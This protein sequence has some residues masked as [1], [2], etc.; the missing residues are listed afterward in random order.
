MSNRMHARRMSQRQLAR[1]A[2]VDHSTVSRVLRRS[3]P[4]ARDGAC[5][6]GCA[7]NPGR[8]TSRAPEQRANLHPAVLSAMLYRDGLLT[9]DEIDELGA[10]GRIRGPSRRAR[11][12]RDRF[13]APARFGPRAAASRDPA[14]PTLPGVARRG[15]V[16]SPP[17]DVRCE[18]RGEPRARRAATGSAGPPDGRR[19]RPGCRKCHSRSGEGHRRRHH[20]P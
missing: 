16:R 14:L 8:R 15:S 18:A 11:A 20:E 19:A 13:A 1:R 7:R 6:P 12:A 5:A 17:A 2:G 3:G 10:R 4:N 9:N